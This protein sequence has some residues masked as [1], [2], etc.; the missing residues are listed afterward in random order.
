MIDFEQKYPI[1]TSQYVR[2]LKA[3]SI[4]DGWKYNIVEIAFMTNHRKWNWFKS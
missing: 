2:I 1:L 4:L 3:S